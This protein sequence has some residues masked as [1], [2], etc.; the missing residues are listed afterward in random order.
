MK[1]DYSDLEKLARA[2]EDENWRFRSF[3]KFYDKMSD[4]Q[5][6]ALVFKTT[7][8][9]WSSI[10]CTE[11]GRCCME[12]T[13]LLSEKDQERLAKGLKITV[14]Q[15]K[16]QYLEYDETDDEPGWRIKNSPCPF[17]QDKK[18]IAGLKEW[19][20]VLQ[21]GGVFAS[22]WPSVWWWAR[23]RACAASSTRQRPRPPSR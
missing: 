16:K 15:L 4:E 6:D 9:V 3:L 14:E 2:K 12:M 19:V 17:L 10:D 22:R 13:P 11:C 7:D 23:T 8:E 21:S 20:S 1:S 5:V 18:C